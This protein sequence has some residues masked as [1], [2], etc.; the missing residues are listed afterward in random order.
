MDWIGWEMLEK[1]KSDKDILI[2]IRNEM[3]EKCFEMTG[4]DKAYWEGLIEGY[5][6]QI[7]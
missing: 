5:D 2:G 7:R 6:T 1:L 3:E 4:D